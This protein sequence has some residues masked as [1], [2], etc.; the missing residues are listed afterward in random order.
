VEPYLLAAG[1]LSIAL[2]IIHSTMGEILIFRRMRNGHI[3]PTNGHPILRERHVRIL[4][5]TWHLATIF[6][7]GLGAILLHYSTPSANHQAFIENT[8]LFSMFS[9]ALLVLIGT[10]GK[11]PGWVVLLTVAILLVIK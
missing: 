4:W 3:I 1:C 6:G 10:K 8:I 7:W 9:G 2:G 11:H 5:A